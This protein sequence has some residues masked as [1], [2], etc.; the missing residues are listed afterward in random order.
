LRQRR[1]ARRKEQTRGVLLTAA[2]EAFVARGYHATKISD[3][4][5]RARVGQGTFYRHFDNKRQAFQALF[6]RFVASLHA[7]FADMS[8]HP[9]TGIEEYMSASR[10]AVKRAARVVM[11][12]QA[13]TLLFLREGP[14]I[15]RE[16]ERNLKEM[17]E[18]FG[19]LA[20]H[21]LDAAIDG[22]FAR[23]CDTELVS[24]SIVGMGLWQLERFLSGR[25]G[26]ADLDAAIDELVRFAFWGFGPRGA[27]A[28]IQIP[29]RER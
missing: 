3:V 27:A 22:G 20:R 4:A 13:L 29:E 8:A 6:D 1:D 2:R 21:Y 11:A 12:D 28:D 17:C 15:D 25:A 7:E 23:S 9:P 19:A 5:A 24:Q 10:N 16:F 18:G 26:G 14:A